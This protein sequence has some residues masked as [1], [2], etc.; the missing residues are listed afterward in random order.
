MRTYA[1]GAADVFRFDTEGG[2]G[3]NVVHAWLDGD[4]ASGPIC[5]SVDEAVEALRE[6]EARRRGHGTMHD[7]SEVLVASTGSTATASGARAT[8]GSS[9]ARQ[10]RGS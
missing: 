5:W 2:R 10:D 4:R 8:W 6:L 7:V 3:A 9:D 1:V